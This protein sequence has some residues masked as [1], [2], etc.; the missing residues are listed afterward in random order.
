VLDNLGG[1]PSFGRGRR[2]RRTEKDNF[3]HYWVLYS[4]VF[5]GNAPG[6]ISDGILTRQLHNQPLP[7]LPGILTFKRSTLFLHA[8]I[9]SP[10]QLPGLNPNP[11]RNLAGRRLPAAPLA[12]AGAAH[13]HP[14]D[15]FIRAARSSPASLPSAGSISWGWRWPWWDCSPCSASFLHAMAA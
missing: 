1:Q 2:G 5:P 4:E 14:R 13:L 12:A 15:Q 10:C 8:I 7:T 3:I 9:I 6:K 11:T